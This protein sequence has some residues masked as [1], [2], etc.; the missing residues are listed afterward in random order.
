M[1]YSPFVKYYIG[2][3]GKY[4]ASHE[5]GI[6]NDMNFLRI[7]EG[8]FQ[9][10]VPYGKCKVLNF[11]ESIHSTYYH[12]NHH[13]D[14]FLRYLEIGNI[15]EDRFFGHIKSYDYNGMLIKEGY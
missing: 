2:E 3:V 1:H 15:F 10:F 13:K 9:K 6:L 11:N 8:Y 4:Y 5:T 7:I 14:Y 12:F